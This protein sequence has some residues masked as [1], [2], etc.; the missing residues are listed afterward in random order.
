MVAQVLFLL[1]LIPMFIS[2]QQIRVFAEV[3]RD[4]VEN[5]PIMGNLSIEHP[6][7]KTI[8][9]LSIQL[10]NKPLVA[11]QIKEVR[12]SP[13]DPL[14]LT[15][16]R[17]Q[18]PGMEKGLHVLD[19]ISVDVGGKIYKTTPSSFEVKKAGKGPVEP[20]AVPSSKGKPAAPEKKSKPVLVLES[21]VDPDISLYPGQRTKVGYRY[22]FNQNIQATNEVLP[23]LDAEGFKKIG[24]KVTRTAQ[25][26]EMSLLEVSQEIEAIKPG[27]YSFGPSY[28]E[29]I[30]TDERGNQILPAIKTET[31]V[32]KIT[33]TALPQSVK[34]PSYKN[35]I[36]H[37]TMETSLTSTSNVE[38][39]E[40]MVLKV[41]IK[42]AP[43][44]GIDIPDL[45]CQPGMAGRFH[46]SDIPPAPILD[47]GSVQFLVE[48]RPM[49]AELK[50]IPALEF[51][52]F[53]PDKGTYERTYSKAIPIQVRPIVTKE[54]S[55][56]ASEGW[57]VINTTPRPIPIAGLKEIPESSLLS[58]W[59]LNWWGLLTIPLAI[60]IIYFQI[61]LKK[62]LSKLRAR[63]RV[64]TSKQI[65]DSINHQSNDE[66][67][68]KLREC[69]LLKLQEMGVIQ[70]PI[71]YE[72]LSSEVKQDK[73][74]QFLRKVDAWHY[75]EDTTPAKKLIQ[76]AQSLYKELS[77]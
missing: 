60:G 46:L 10:Q 27:E 50:E 3:D 5:T 2:A 39:G 30:A 65:L 52:F 57:P 21:F 48:I 61:G 18:I 13:N 76:E 63:E 26:N 70:N 64:L 7:T 53:N 11:E 54:E 32:V 59:M 15:I 17:F 49:D 56:K 77:K 31:P 75:T 6:N 4:P 14:T 41:V 66:L 45:C 28:Y 68:G 36:G 40:K 29:G 1:L 9:K 55:L 62:G 44:E 67:P 58:R 51:S 74:K 19:S 8:N 33:V 16:F 72:Q 37:F 38:V 20:V 24:G 43:L 35:A 42:G 23:L 71:P 12:Y 34:P 69:F 22:Y 47:E 73:V 25:D